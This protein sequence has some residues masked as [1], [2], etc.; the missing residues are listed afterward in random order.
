MPII[1]CRLLDIG[2]SQIV[3]TVMLQPRLL[4]NILIVFLDVGLG[5]MIPI[6][7]GEHQIRE[8]QIIPQI[9]R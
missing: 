6:G 4:Q 3:E 1:F 5:I 7:L 2:V 8:S 9:A